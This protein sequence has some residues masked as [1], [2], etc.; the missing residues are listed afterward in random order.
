MAT[1]SWIIVR[2]ELVLISASASIGG[3]SDF[4][5]SGAQSFTAHYL[6]E[7]C[8]KQ[9]AYAR[10]TTEQEGG[11]T[12]EGRAEQAIPLLSAQDFLRYK[13]HEVIGFHRSLPPFK[14]ERMD[15]RQRPILQ[16]RRMVPLRSYQPLRP[17][18]IYPCR[19][20]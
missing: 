8:G 11:H 1:P 20:D 10:H 6:E 16:K 5:T 7:R 19:E 14:L 18:P 15:W 9:S 3:A 4:R 2:I 12:I 17:L 13:D